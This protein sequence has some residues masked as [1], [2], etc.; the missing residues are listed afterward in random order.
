MQKEQVFFPA[1]LLLFGLDE[2]EFG[3]HVVEE[4]LFGFELRLGFVDE[5]FWRL[6]YVVWIAE[7]GFERVNLL[8]KLEDAV[9]EVL[10]VL[11]VKVGWDFE[12]DVWMAGDSK[13]EALSVFWF[14]LWYTWSLGVVLNEELVFVDEF[15]VV[16]SDWIASGAWEALE[17]TSDI[18]DD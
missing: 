14:N 2:L 13:V 7:A 5:L 11:C 1:L 4:F 10:L 17:V 15:I 6:F 16:E 8:A 9:L 18:R 12:I 3:F